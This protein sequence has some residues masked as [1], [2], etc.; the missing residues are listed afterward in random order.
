MS[1][2]G[3]YVYYLTVSEFLARGDQETRGYRV[4]GKV[5]SGTIERLPTGQD[6]HFR[7]HDGAQSLDV[8][9]HGIIPDTFVDDAEVVV[10]G[11]RQ[12]DGVFV[13]HTLLAKCPSKYESADAADAN[14]PSAS[15][16]YGSP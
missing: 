14:P 8:T 12:S 15:E 3:G 2:A 4:N 1:G 10:E 6:V 5:L 11:R 16:G 9:F 13:A 7:M